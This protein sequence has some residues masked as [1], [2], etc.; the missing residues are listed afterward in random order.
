MGAL[1][2][3]RGAHPEAFAEAEEL[4]V[5]AA[6]SLGIRDLRRALDHWRGAVD[7]RAAEDADRERYERRNLHVSPTF[8]GM[9]RVDGDLDPENGQALLTALRAIGDAD[10]R[11]GTEQSRSPAQRRADA[12]GEVCRRWLDRSDR[13]TV[14]G[15]RPH[16]I[17]TVDVDA[18]RGRADGSAALDRDIT[19]S[20]SSARRLACD[21]SVVRVLTRGPSQPLDV[22]RRTAVVP[23][24]IRRALIVRDGGCALPACDRPP[25]WA[26]AHHVRHWADGGPTA[27][28]NLTVALPA[29]PSVDPWRIVLGRDRGG[30]PVFRRADGSPLDDRAPP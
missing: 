4:L 30:R 2:E 25:S 29:T 22:G 5:D 19:I 28:S 21:A 12:L 11:N 10:V 17:V 26:D 14:A 16:M 6:R 23:P 18:L 13:P 8:D 9:V 20:P 15:E 24:A 1:V 7:H 3:A 27:L